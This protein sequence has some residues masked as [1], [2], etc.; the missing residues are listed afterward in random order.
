MSYIVFTIEGGIGK[1]I[2]ATAVCQAIAE[3]RP[4]KKLVVVS[5][6]PD[7]FINNPHVS[8]ALA[9]GS[10]QYFY[11]T[12]I[13]DKDTEILV[14]NPYSV[15]DY[16]YQR[17]NLVEIW[18]NLF[19][20]QYDAKYKP[21]IFLTQ[22]EVDF[23]AKNFQTDKPF[24]A[25]QTN[26]GADNQQ[27]K[28]SWARD[29][30]YNVADAVVQHFKDKYRIIH[31]RRQ[32]QLELRDTQ[33][34]TASFREIVV[35][36]SMTSKRL[37]M[38]SFAQHIAG[39]LNLPST[40][41]WITNSPIVFGYEINNNILANPYTKQPELRNAF[42]QEFNI[43]GDLVEFPYYSETE[44][45]DIDKIIASLEDVAPTQIVPPTQVVEQ[46]QDVQATTEN[47]AELVEFT[48]E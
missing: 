38:D 34:L 48:H 7:V 33:T 32:D 43:G 9:F 15:T 24:F 6:Y 10:T 4:D 40:V 2:M 1:C 41:C 30:P 39:S 42:L 22:R 27:L 35:F 37:L 17:K 8:R 16:I 36:M 25:I 45:F 19:G 13:K 11:E 3:Q 46:L 20:L 12:Y 23:F 29:I 18:C 44:I 47:N 21:Q 5:G 28:Y 31:I 14:H 26:G